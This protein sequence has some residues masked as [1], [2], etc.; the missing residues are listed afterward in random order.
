[1]GP[2]LASILALAASEATLA[3]GVTLLLFYAL[4][5]AL[6]FLITA[7]A[8]GHFLAAYRRFRRH[9]RGVELAGGTLM[10]AVGILVLTRHLT[11]VN[12]WLNDLA[13]FRSIAEHFL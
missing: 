1:M 6:P 4:G 2:I 7:L 12:A 3:T 11:V 13:V 9:L 5:L 8:I 10:I